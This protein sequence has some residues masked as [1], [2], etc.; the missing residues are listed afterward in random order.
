MVL[1]TVGCGVSAKSPKSAEAPPLD[2]TQH[3][4][5][6]SVEPAPFNK[7]AGAAAPSDSAEVQEFLQRDSF[8]RDVL[9]KLSL[10]DFLTDNLEATKDIARS[11]PDI[12]YAEYRESE[13]T[14][15]FLDEELF[16]IRYVLPRTRQSA[17]DSI[18]RYRKAFG[19]PTTTIVP[20]DFQDLNASQFQ[21]WELPQHHLR[22]NFAYVAA[23]FA[24]ADVNLVG[25]FIN[26]K[27]A[28]EFLTRRTRGET[29]AP[30]RKKVDTAPKTSSARRAIEELIADPEWG[31]VAAIINRLC[32]GQISDADIHR[33]ILKTI[34][35]AR[36]GN[37]SAQFTLKLLLQ[38]ETL[39]SQL[40]VSPVIAV[41]SAQQSLATWSNTRESNPS[42]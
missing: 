26:M 32:T 5:K 23:G 17:A 6:I 34:K 16:A 7:Q 11:R 36:N 31:K 29:N 1:L 42:Q 25:Q 40:M 38:G 21:R 22:I 4:S 15:Q 37:F 18:A 8:C 35:A 2:N 12:R 10:T 33:Q 30:D 24:E 14:Y 28:K 13:F 41:Q 9:S 19:P 27:I 39:A 3:E 20:P